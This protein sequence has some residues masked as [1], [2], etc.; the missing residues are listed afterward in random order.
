MSRGGL[1]VL[2]T[3]L[4]MR[5]TMRLARPLS[6]LP[7]LSAL[8]EPGLGGT[9]VVREQGRPVTRV[10]GAVSVYGVRVL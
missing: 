5:L 2:T 4:A 8:C 9:V 7:A 6:T 1:G 3:Y 10:G